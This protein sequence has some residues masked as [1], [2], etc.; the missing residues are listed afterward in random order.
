MP[1]EVFVLPAE[2]YVEDAT[3]GTAYRPKY[4]DDDRFGGYNSAL[5]P[6][7][8]TFPGM[9]TPS[10]QVFVAAV[11][12]TQAAIDDIVTATDVWAVGRGQNPDVGLSDDAADVAAGQVADYLNGEFRVDP[13][14][15]SDDATR[16]AIR[17]V[18]RDDTSL[19]PLTAD[20]WFERLGIDPAN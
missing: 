20:E 6:A 5:I 11:T 15:I 14:K 16:D 19:E 4:I 13:S 8:D 10:G 9:S 3:G 12:A 1:T 17:K 7:P 2:E 18:V